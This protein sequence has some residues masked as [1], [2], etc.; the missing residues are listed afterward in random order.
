MRIRDGKIRIRD[1]HSESAT[2]TDTRMC[3]ALLHLSIYPFVGGW[4]D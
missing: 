1:K 3:A 2:L 4:W